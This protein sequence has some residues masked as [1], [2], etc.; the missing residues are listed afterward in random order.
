MTLDELNPG[1]LIYAA[2]DILNDGAFPTWP[3]A[4]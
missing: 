4:R 1:D 2:T 3:R